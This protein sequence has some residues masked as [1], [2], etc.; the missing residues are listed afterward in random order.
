MRLIDAEGIRIKPEC[1]HDICGMAM[2][3]VED[4]VRIINEQ[5]TIRRRSG[6]WISVPLKRARICSCCGCDEP[7]KFADDDADIY[8]FCPHCGADMRGAI[9]E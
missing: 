4:I 3:R 1:M 9:C 7:Y 6:G 2:I 8:N 5:P